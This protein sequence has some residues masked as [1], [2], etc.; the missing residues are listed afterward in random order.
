MLRRNGALIDCCIIIPYYWLLPSIAPLWIIENESTI[1]QPIIAAVGFEP[2]KHHSNSFTANQISPLSYTTNQWCASIIIQV[3]VP[4]HLLCVN[5]LPIRTIM[6][7]WSS[8][9]LDSYLWEGDGRSVY[10][11]LTTFKEPWF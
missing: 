6:N 5:L 7:H 1:P 8:S 10:S 9:L 3:Q 2:T 4:L 11:I